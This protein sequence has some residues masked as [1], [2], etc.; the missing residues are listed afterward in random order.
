MM[1]RR[2]AT[3]RTLVLAS[4]M[5]S[6][7]LLAGVT[8]AFGTDFLQ[9]AAKLVVQSSGSRERLTLIAR[10]PPPQA[11][12]DDP[13]AVGGTFEV[14]NPSTGESAIFDLPA[15]GWSVNDAGSVIRFRNPEAPGG[16]SE[17]KLASI[18]DGKEVKVT[19]RAV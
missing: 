19:A 12:M 11:P 4:L 10:M 2:M 15:A 18:R 7:G 13:R 17:V 5:G 1:Q 16:L 8:A 9:G 3:R 6:A 14:I